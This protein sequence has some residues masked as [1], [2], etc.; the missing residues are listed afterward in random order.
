MKILL[1]EDDL[2]LGELIV[3][4][5]KKKAD[6]TVEWVQNG[7]DALDWASVSEYDV[8]VLD[9][10]LPGKDGCRVCRELRSGGYS[11]A[12]LML[13]AKDALEDRVEGLDAG[14]D[15]YLVKPFAIDELLAR[16]RA[17]GRRT[18]LPLEEEITRLGGLELH[19][20]SQ[21]LVAG[22]RRKQ[23]TPR[24]FQLLNLLLRHAGQVLPRELI[25]DRIWGMEKEVAI[26]T[27]DA[28]VKLLR[29]R[30]QPLGIAP[31]WIE[32]IRGVG[33]R[34]GKESL[35]ENYPQPPR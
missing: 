12:I 11:G 27:V 25:L 5:L 19:R 13:T 8:L 9:W 21:T 23:L 3:H 18:F 31:D 2:G 7:N 15:D 29:K 35:P 16:L 34:I 4:L 33:Y 28:T 10:M 26:K 32:S 14:A 6:Y 24:E 17:L 1:A 22:G 30:L 20:S